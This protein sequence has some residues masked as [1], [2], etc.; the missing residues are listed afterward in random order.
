MPL[1]FWGKRKVRTALFAL[2]CAFLGQ[3]QTSNLAIYIS[4]AKIKD[5]TM[6]LALL[7]TLLGQI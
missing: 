5:Q 7:C 6:P 4:G 2:S 3:I 1:R